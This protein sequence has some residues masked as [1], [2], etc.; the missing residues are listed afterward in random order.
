MKQLRRFPCAVGGE[1][2][3]HRRQR[4]KVIFSDVGRRR[5]GVGVG[6]VGAFR[7]AALGG[8]Y[9]SPWGGLP[10]PLCVTA[11]GVTFSQKLFVDNA[12][13]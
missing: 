4:Q 5:W 13:Q 9:C 7:G 11:N 1:K 3:K 2:W 8:G 6:G 12:P 10:F